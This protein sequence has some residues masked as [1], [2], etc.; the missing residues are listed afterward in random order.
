MA[1]RTTARYARTW[2]KY[3][4]LDQ[5]GQ[6]K[7]RGCEFRKMIFARSF[8]DFSERNM[9]LKKTNFGPI[10]AFCTA[11]SENNGREKRCTSLQDTVDR[12][13]LGEAFAAGRSPWSKET[14]Q[15]LLPIEKSGQ[16]VQK[17]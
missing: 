8:N 14:L 1:K 7:L 10:Y 3:K 9:Y 12:H 17:N 4:L 11:V 6:E 15:K 5:G 16:A 2:T 13:P